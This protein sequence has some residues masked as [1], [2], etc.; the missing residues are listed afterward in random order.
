MSFKSSLVVTLGSAFAGAA[1]MYVGL[2]GQGDTRTLS[3]TT[4]TV[5]QVSAPAKPA[6]SKYC[7]KK[8]LGKVVN[9]TTPS[10]SA[11]YKIKCTVKSTQAWKRVG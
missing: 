1:L 7:S 6:P 3:P 5:E 9:Y 11:T 8:L 2:S 4:I 10:R